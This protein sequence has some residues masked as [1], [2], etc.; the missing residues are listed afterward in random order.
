MAEER[1]SYKFDYLLHSADLIKDYLRVQLL[2]LEISPHQARVI[3]VLD[4]MGPVSQIDLAREFGITAASMSTMTARLIALGLVRSEKDPLNAKR[5]VISLTRKGKALR[6]KIN[7]VWESADAFM[8]EKIGAK[9]MVK[10]AEITRSLRDSPGGL[11]P[12]D[13]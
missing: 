2:P 4:R 13:K 11:V 9:N 3:K 7:Q 6:R 1:R 8:E 5:N 12:D 10:L